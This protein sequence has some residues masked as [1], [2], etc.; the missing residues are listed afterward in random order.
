MNVNDVILQRRSIRKYTGRVIEQD[1]LDTILKAGFYAPTARNVQPT[2]FV[3][4]KDKKTLSQIAEE[5]PNAKYCVEA[6]CGIL[7]C[8]DKNADVDG[9]LVENASAAIQNMLLSAHELGLGTV[10]CGVYPRDARMESFVEILDLPENI[11][12]VGFVIAGYPDEV[13]EVPERV[14]LARVHYEKW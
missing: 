2:S 13:K 8:G 12:P 1:K 14:D 11:L 4:I 6:G 3:V 10:W 9:Y 7:V 5:Q